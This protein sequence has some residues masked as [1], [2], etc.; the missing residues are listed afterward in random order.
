[1]VDRWH[2][3]KNLREALERSIEDVY[4]RSEARNIAI[5]S[6]GSEQALRTRFPRSGADE[7][8]REGKR[9]QRIQRYQIVQELKARGMSMRRISRLLGL[10]RGTVRNFYFADTYPETQRQ[11]TKPSILDPYL[12]YLERRVQGGCTNAKQLWRE[13]VAQGYPGAPGQVSKWMTWR[14]RQD[15][16]GAS[17]GMSSSS[18]NS[19]D[20]LLPSRKTLTRIL[21]ADPSRLDPHDLVLLNLVKQHRPIAAIHEVVRRFR[22]MIAT[23]Q[24]ADFDDW[25]AAC[26]QS[27]VGAMER[28]ADSIQQDRTAVVAAISTDWSNGQTEGHVNR[29]KMLK[30]Q[31]YGR[32]N[33]DLLR[34]RV[35]Y[36]AETT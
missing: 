31:M 6:R 24:T 12:P 2:L 29:L 13:I 15:I 36:R 18:E 3:V 14:R 19:V 27:N 35:L 20:V 7:Q 30:R 33:L 11:K 32:A 28:F 22:I 25:L 10:A 17:A 16:D 9:E 23:K 4:P 21:S 26:Y 5:L 34:A 1:M 8:L